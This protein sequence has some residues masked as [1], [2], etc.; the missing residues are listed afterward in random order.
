MNKVTKHATLKTDP[1]TFSSEKCVPWPEE[2]ISPTFQLY[3]GFFQA[4]T[5][6]CDC[7]QS[8]LSHNDLHIFFQKIFH[9]CWKNQSARRKPEGKNMQTMTVLIGKLPRSLQSDAKETH[10][11][12]Y[13]TLPWGKHSSWTSSSTKRE[14]IGSRSS[15][16]P[17]SLSRCLLKIKGH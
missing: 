3:R 16:S 1:V 6:M 4:N 2:D 11:E 15:S 10:I 17:S 7:L 14:R 13:F 5:D 8:D 9:V 12:Y